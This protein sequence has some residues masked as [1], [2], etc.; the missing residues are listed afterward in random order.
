MRNSFLVS[1][2]LLSFVMSACG[3][4][5]DDNGGGGGPNPDKDGDGFLESEG[6]CDD[7]DRFTYPGAPD[8][9][10]GIDQNCDGT[11]DEAFDADGDLST[12]CGGD[13][14]DN[15][16]TSRP[17]APEVIDG[18]DNDC[19]GIID[20]HT[21]AYD[22]DGDG[23]SEQQGDCN[24]DPDN[25]GRTQ[26][27]GAIEVQLD[28]NGDPENIDNDCDGEV[29]EALEPCDA[30]TDPQDPLHYANAIEACHKTAQASWRPMGID[31]RARGI[32][33]G[34]GAYSPNAGTSLAVLSSGI[35]GDAVAPGYKG[36]D[37]GSLFTGSVPHPDPQGA[38]GCSS[39]D[40][41]NVNDYSEIVLVLDVPTNANAFAFDFNF[42]SA[43]F[44]EWVCDAYD[45]TFLALLESQA[46][47]GNVSF[48]AMG[49]RV[50]INNGFF[51][52]CSTTAFPSYY[53]TE[54]AACTGDA[55]LMGTGYEGAEGGGT[56][57]LTTTSPVKPGEKITLRL[58]V[59]DEGDHSLDSTVLLD[60]FRWLPE[61]IEG[62]ITVPRE[63]GPKRR[64]SFASPTATFSK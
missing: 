26:G 43:E 18:F 16:P 45:D 38:I 15:D 58:A 50:S 53:A 56:G 22:D 46:F 13:C 57:W 24:D 31:T 42:M 8:P 54:T 19:D 30:G 52:V 1:S 47:T 23:Y 35:A 29:D 11:P 10:D 55:N 51:T 17:G 2:L 9:C 28:A 25:L 62:P 21:D 44:P 34:F 61:E 63:F 64:Y 12:T 39:A 59:F 7:N 40:S 6:D 27:P 33:S 32:F 60:N 49:N 4:G 48:D 41:A 3:G 20:N 37:P 14:R 36:T 5:D